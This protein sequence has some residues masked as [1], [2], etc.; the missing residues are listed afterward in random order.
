MNQ[1]RQV[2]GTVIGIQIA[3]GE[4]ARSAEQAQTRRG[5][6]HREL[7]DDI[8]RTVGRAATGETLYRAIDAYIAWL[9]A[10]FVTP[11]EQG[12]EQ[13]TSQTGK[14]Q[15]ERAARLKAHHKNVPLNELYAA[16]G[17]V[18]FLLIQRCDGR[19]VAPAGAFKSLNSF[20]S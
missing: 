1:F 14:K 2:F 17:Q 3:D 13:R 18:G 4:L 10:K 20:D 19:S 11:P 7:A 9:E 5:E 6:H 16:S 15:G 12:E 8:L